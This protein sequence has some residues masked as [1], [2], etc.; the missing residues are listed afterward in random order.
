MFEW[1]IYSFVN[2]KADSFFDVDSSLLKYDL[3]IAKCTD[4]KY[5]VP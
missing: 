3:Y 2:R 5:V 1:I 4:L